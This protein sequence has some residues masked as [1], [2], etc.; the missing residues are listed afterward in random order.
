MRAIQP[1]P[2]FHQR[3]VRA[4]SA[5]RTGAPPPSGVGEPGHVHKPQGPEVV[6]PPHP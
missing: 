4:E 6:G 5:F 3:E 1:G 2:L